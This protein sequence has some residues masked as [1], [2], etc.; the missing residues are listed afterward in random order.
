MIFYFNHLIIKN[1]V[2]MRIHTIGQTAGNRLDLVVSGNIAQG[3]H[4]TQECPNNRAV[5]R[6]GLGS[7]ILYHNTTYPH[8]ILFACSLY[9]LVHMRDSMGDIVGDCM[10]ESMVG[11]SYVPRV[12]VWVVV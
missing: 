11:T 5:L 3:H 7:D 9:I 2:F 6:T 12:Q 10:G 1:S 8:H 4:H